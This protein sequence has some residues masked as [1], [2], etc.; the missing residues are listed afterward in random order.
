MS[1]IPEFKNH[2]IFKKAYKSLFIHLIAWFA[3]HLTFLAKL[4]TH[5]VEFLFCICH[6]VNLN[7]IYCVIVNPK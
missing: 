7:T 1:F 2:A 4:L 6:G 3:K 5:I